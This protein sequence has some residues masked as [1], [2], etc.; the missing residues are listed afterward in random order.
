MTRIVHSYA[1]HIVFEASLE[2][3]WVLN[4]FLFHCWWT[5]VQ[6]LCVSLL[7]TWAV[8]DN[9]DVPLAIFD[10]S[11]VLRSLLNASLQMLADDEQIKQFSWSKRDFARAKGVLCSHTLSGNWSAVF[12]ASWVRVWS[13]IGG[14]SGSF[15][16]PIEVDIVWAKETKRFFQNKPRKIDQG[17][18]AFPIYV[19]Y[20]FL[21]RR[22]GWPCR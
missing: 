1:A 12:S 3:G 13:G 17:A 21:I 22:S 6:D 15:P 5:K 8:K 19:F 10:W 16:A 9:L 18:Y 11:V 7:K 20:I 4:C 2:H 14:K